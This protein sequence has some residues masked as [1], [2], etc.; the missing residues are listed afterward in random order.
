MNHREKAGNSGE[1]STAARFSALEPESLFGDIESHLTQIMVRIDGMRNATLGRERPEEALACDPAEEA[2][3]KA[4]AARWMLRVSKHLNG[5]T[6]ERVLSAVRRS[7]AELDR[8]LESGANHTA[9][10]DY[11]RA[12]H[13]SARR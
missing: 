13:A 8:I 5:S 3:V 7:V 4:E 6:R 12:S 1:A 10:P 11:S 2:E 9:P